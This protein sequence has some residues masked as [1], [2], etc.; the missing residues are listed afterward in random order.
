M[1]R[2]TTGLTIILIAIAFFSCREDSLEKQR[3]N[4]LSKFNEFIRTHYAGIDQRPSG[5]YYIEL[6]EGTGDSIKIGDRVQIFFDLWTL[7]NIWV[8]GTGSFEPLEMV[9]LHPN[10]LSSSAKVPEQLRSLN[11][12][13][14]Y[15][16]WGTKSLLVFDSALGYG[17]FGT[18]GIPGFTS[19]MME[20][21]VYKV[22]PSVT[23]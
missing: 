22:F 17:Q 20:V 7:D 5:L 2:I 23:P 13:L 1:R 19:L 14:T 12:A 9:V 8:D 16:K 18:F 6:E 4:E 11:E 15:M 10:D 3:Q 21:K